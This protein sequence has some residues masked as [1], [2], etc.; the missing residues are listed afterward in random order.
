MQKRVKDKLVCKDS[1]VDVL[2]NYWEK[3]EFQLMQNAAPNTA[4]GRPMD[5]EG[6]NFYM[7]LH[8]VPIEV[9]EAVLRE[10]TQRCRK[11]HSI[12]FWQ[13]RRMYPND[14]RYDEN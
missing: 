10:F 11:I 12:C 2:L 13:W 6:Q 5:E 3:V 9:R 4:K 7:K 14:L 8:R 1:K